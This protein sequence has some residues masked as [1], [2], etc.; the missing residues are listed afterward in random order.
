M[1]LRERT[2]RQNVPPDAT[3]GVFEDPA[4]HAIGLVEAKP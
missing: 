2:Q 3:L 1:L 4:G